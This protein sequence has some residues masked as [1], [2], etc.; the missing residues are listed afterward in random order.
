MNERE[1]KKKEI[2]NELSAYFE[3]LVNDGYAK[4]N[5]MGQT[6][7][8]YLAERMLIACEQVEREFEFSS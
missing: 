1:A 6:D 7:Y 8:E 4:A 5:T 3:V 2:I